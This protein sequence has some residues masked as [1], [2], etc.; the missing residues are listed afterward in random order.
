MHD[1][2]VNDLRS[3]SIGELELV[4]KR[5]NDEMLRRRNEEREKKINAFQRAWNELKDA[6]IRISYCEDYEDDIIHLDYW[7]GFNFD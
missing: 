4:S 7:D 3:M 5:I 2:S 1:I 6:G